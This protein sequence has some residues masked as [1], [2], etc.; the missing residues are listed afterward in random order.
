MSSERKSRLE[1]LPG[2]SWDILS[3]QWE[4]GFRYLNEFADREGHCLIPAQYITKDEYQLGSWINRQ[5]T[6]KDNLSQD[7]KARLEAL[8]GWSWDPR[9]DKWG[10]GF[11]YLKKFTIHEGHA[12]VPSNWETTD[13]YRLGQW[14]TSQ[15]SKK[16]N[17]SSERKDRLEALSGW[18]WG[19]WSE[20]W[21]EGLRHLEKFVEREGHCLPAAQYKSDD[22]YRVGG[23]VSAQ[24][25][26][27]DNLS[28]E[29][30]ERLEALPGW[31]WD[32]IEAQW[33]KGFHYLKEF[34][35]R[36]GH[37]KVPNGHLTAD[38]YRLGSWVYIQ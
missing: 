14:V 11:R 26:K 5:R 33:E 7:C 31:S 10:G 37:S 3:A 29:C 16:E 22:G 32:V 38:G 34:V 36:E 8:S 12:N 25:V 27:K 1:A 35:D 4:D 23:W 28:R 6:R 17:M 24:R 20:K 15:R 13:G 21:E 9:A 2:W 30:I 19:T 18:C